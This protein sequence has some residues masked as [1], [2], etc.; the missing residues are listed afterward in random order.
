MNN[1]ADPIT[2]AIFICAAFFG[3]DVAAVI[4][5]Y[6]VIAIAASAGAGWAMFTPGVMP[7]TRYIFIYWLL[8]TVTATLLTSGI[9]A[10][11]AYFIGF[12]IGTIDTNIL[13]VPIAFAI[14]AIGKRWHN[15]GK[16]I[17]SIIERFI[18]PKG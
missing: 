13:L 16:W 4:G 10:L 15:V 7:E 14:G 18:R 6:I 1:K 3:Q 11:V 9:A 12:H 2:L 5:P 17:V 8:M